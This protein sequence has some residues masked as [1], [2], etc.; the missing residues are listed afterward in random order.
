V[1]KVHVA[2]QPRIA[3]PKTE[4]TAMQGKIEGRNK[5]QQAQELRSERDVYDQIYNALRP[6]RFIDHLLG[7]AY[8]DLCCRGSEHPLRLSGERYSF[9]AGKN[10]FNVKDGWNGDAER[11]AGTLSGASPSSLLSPCV[12]PLGTSG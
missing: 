1:Q 7:R 10:T 5:V 4:I 3:E 11:L 8:D 12:A 6:D 2:T 9:A